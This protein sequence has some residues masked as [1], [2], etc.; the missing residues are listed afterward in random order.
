MKFRW[1][2]SMLHSPY[3]CM[4]GKPFRNAN[5]LQVLLSARRP[6]ELM[7]VYLAKGALATTAIDGNTLTE[8]EARKRVD[9]IKDLPPSKAYLGV[10]IDN[11]INLTNT[12]LGECQRGEVPRVDVGLIKRFTNRE[13]VL[14]YL[15]PIRK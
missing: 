2:F 8:A 12:V 6:R 14:V 1:T 7:H 13:L 9:G 3:G 10:E 15:P 11:I 4:L 5:I